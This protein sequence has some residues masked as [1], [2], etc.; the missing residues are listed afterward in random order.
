MPTPF[1]GG[2]LCGGVRFEVTPPTLFCCH[3][4][5][6][7][8]RRAH[9]AAF[10]TWLGVPESGF[11]VVMGEDVLRWYGSSWRSQRGFCVRCGTTMLYRSQAAPGEVHVALACVDGEIDRPPQAHVFWEA[12][13]GWVTLGDALPRV[14]RTSPALRKFGDIPEKP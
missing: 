6:H 14:E 12:H 3:C 13:V 2:C 9:G 5:C 1:P 10:V 4:H 11:R 7:W 8:C